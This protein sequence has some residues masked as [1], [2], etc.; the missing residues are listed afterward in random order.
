MWGWLRKAFMPNKVYPSGHGWSVEVDGADL[1]I[2]GAR[3][4]AFGG[5]SD[6]Q[7][8]G[9]TSSGYST[10]GHPMLLGVALPMRGYGVKSLAASPIPRMPF[11]IK[12]NGMPNPGGAMVVITDLITGMKTPPISVIDL[13]PSLYTSNA[14]DLSIAVARMFNPKASATNFERKVDVRIIGGAKYIA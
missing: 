13:G 5:S 8:D 12:S 7:D 11:G 1:L 9:A 6:P 3:A 4:T 14:I 2:R 10:K